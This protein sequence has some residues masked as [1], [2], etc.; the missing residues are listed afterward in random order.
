MP[1]IKIISMMTTCESNGG[2]QYIAKDSTVQFNTVQQLPVAD[3]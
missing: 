2:A 1:D 3:I